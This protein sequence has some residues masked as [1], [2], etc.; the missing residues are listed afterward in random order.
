MSTALFDLKLRKGDTL[1]NETI[2]LFVRLRTSWFSFSFKSQTKLWKILINGEVQPLFKCNLFLLRQSL[3]ILLLFIKIIPL[4]LHKFSSFLLVSWILF[5][6]SW[7]LGRIIL[8]NGILMLSSVSYSLMEE[9]TF[10][11]F[12]RVFTLFWILFVPVWTMIKLGFFE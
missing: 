2:E 1:E 8:D 7:S 10:L 12:W 11:I 9:I 5:L 6:K 3:S 4:P